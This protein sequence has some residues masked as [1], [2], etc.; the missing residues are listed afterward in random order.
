MYGNEHIYC[1]QELE[2]MITT[3]FWVNIG[4][5]DKPQGLTIL[6]PL[7]QSTDQSTQST[8]LVM[9]KFFDIP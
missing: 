7:D 8:E 3:L 4:G 5:E 2:V 6:S 1:T 9:Y